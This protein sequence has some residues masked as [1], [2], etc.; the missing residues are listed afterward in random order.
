MATIAELQIKVDST[1]AE[2]GV[3][4]LNDL[5][6]AADKAA[7]ARKALNDVS[8]PGNGGGGGG[9]DD[10][11]AKKTR[12]LSEAI[13]AQTRKLADLAAQRKKL[14]DDPMKT[15]NPAEYARLNREIDARTELVNRQ[16]N[17]LDRLA[18]QANKE[19]RSREQAAKSAQAL[20]DREAKQLEARE[21]LQARLAASQQRQL[22]ATTAGL[23]AQ[24]K[25]QQEYNK[26][27]E[28]LSLNRFQGKIGG[29]E[30][31]TLIKMAA[32]RRD[33][34]LATQDN[35]KELERNQRMLDSIT[36]TLGR[37]ERAEV[38]L[39]R[40]TDTLN[41]SLRLGIVTQEQYDKQL[42]QHT[43][44]RDAAIA[45]ANN[46]TAAEARFS[47]QLKSVLSAYNPII[48]ATDEYAASQAILRQG[49]SQG[50][51]NIRQYIAALKEQ[52]AALNAVKAAQ[53]GSPEQQAKQYQS[54]LDR[55]LP[56]NAQLRNLAEAE[57]Q[58]QAAQ[59][60]G[61][62]VTAEQIKS[63]EQATKAIAAERAEIERRNLADR[64]GNS[65]KQD[66]AALRGLPAQFTDVV[67]SLQGGQAPLTVLL[68]QGGQ[69]KDMFGGL[70]PMFKAVGGALLA[71]ITPVTVVGA[72]L[73]GIAVAFYQGS[74]EA[75]DF[76]KAIASSAGYSGASREAFL[77]L[78]KSISSVSGTMA[79]A[80]E[81][82]IEMQKS[83]KISVEQFESIG[84]AAA[85]MQ[86]VTGQAIA[87]TVS[88]FASLGKDPVNAVASLDEK[89]KFLTAS[90]Y[91]QIA[92]MQRSGDIMGATTLAQ[93]EMAKGA[94]NLAD[95]IKENLGYIEKGWKAVKEGAAQAWDEMRGIGRD[96]SMED[97]ISK[98]K[99]RIELMKKYNQPQYSEAQGKTVF[100]ESGLKDLQDELKTME[101][102]LGVVNKQKEAQA[103]L[104]KE[105]E[106]GRQADTRFAKQLQTD[107]VANLG[108]V[109]LLTE[110]I[111]LLKTGFNEATERAKANGKVVESNVTET[112]NTTVKNLE[113]KLDIAKEQ[114]ARAAAGPNTPLDTREIQD[115]K[116][117]LNV[118]LSE[119]DGYYKKVTAL[120]KA[121]VVS[122]EATYASQKAILQ[123][124]AK[125]VSASYDEQIESIKKLQDKKGNNAAQTI[126]LGN[127]MSRAEDQRT[128]SMQDNAAKQERLD[129][130]EAGRIEAKTSRIE[131]YNDALR[132]SISNTALAGQ[133]AVSG[134]G[135][136]DRQG[137]LNE[138]LGDADRQFA[139]DQLSL[140]KQLGKTIDQD[141]FDQKM[142]AL[143]KAHTDMT[144]QILKNDADI[145]AAEGDWSNGLTKALQ[146]HIAEGQN[147]AKV[148]GQAFEV[149]FDGM[150][151]GLAEFVTTGKL[152]FKSL[153]SS[154]IGDLARLAIKLAMNQALSAMFG[155]MSGGGSGWGALISAGVGAFSGGG[156]NGLAAGSAGAVSSNLGASSAGYSNQFF[157]KG[158]A[159]TNSIVSSPTQFSMGN[160]KTG[161]MGED[162]AEAIIP[163]AKTSDG[164]LGVRMVGGGQVS[165]G[166]QV[167][168]S[169]QSNGTIETSTT[170]PGLAQFGKDIG[171]FVDK[172]YQANL[173]RDL[174]DG[175]AIKT[176]MKKT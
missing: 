30:Y 67:V 5:A 75:V 161:T 141:E 13:D 52:Q 53:T 43:A 38:T 136:G 154:I 156:G 167:Y 63:H 150:A 99:Q 7:K 29:P 37:A 70:I 28:V 90:V 157:A 158:G 8:G 126:S 123:A 47:A 113:K 10:A 105:K 98:M 93:E 45:A 125:A 26:T 92:A 102:A 21:A 82:L 104:N 128:K 44:K 4:V 56:F 110:K 148:M 127:Q 122:A 42:G 96:V 62:V 16:G 119:Y 68:Q 153:V 116:S 117:N 103:L 163:L 146:N 165:G 3:K 33:E 129:I 138:D 24:I 147:V 77:N 27:V 12:N 72:A 84:I 114:A 87:D 23:S 14:N 91:L 18:A 85:K 9:A 22:D 36:A 140:S 94:T 76:N 71:L 6:T 97:Q 66:A 50:E 176:A 175:G 49:L 170:E 15:E 69:L 40:A 81:A 118:V 100:G 112:Y 61:L 34:A 31:D 137:K 79:L 164:S 145:K 173:A 73:A 111:S 143:K 106:Q 107:Y 133:R 151:D 172:R 64:R 20:A 55:L 149:A 174:K 1:Q 95:N 2:K 120:G 83:G 51:I 54:A 19:Q 139:R 59:R 109:T 88:D 39:K 11:E 155:G 101:F 108:Q 168:V 135:Q 60:Q 142:D 74:Q 57:R 132:Q 169:I 80:S 115:V 32:A 144:E 89:Y 121:N 152:D 159:F 166:V 162:G 134:V 130:E 65:A 131:A 17:S 25:A 48:K 46:N 58:L 41:E 160:G 86:R 78:Q 124:E 35:T 171:D